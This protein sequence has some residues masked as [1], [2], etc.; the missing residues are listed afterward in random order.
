MAKSEAILA[1]A[2]AKSCLDGLVDECRIE[3]GRVWFQESLYCGEDNE[4]HDV[5]WDALYFINEALRPA[6]LIV[7]NSGSDNDTIWGDIVEI[8]QPSLEV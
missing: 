3:G 4:P 8:E 1:K 7:E 2:K 6:G 5:A